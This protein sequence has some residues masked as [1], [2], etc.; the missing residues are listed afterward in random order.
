M[1][2][3]FWQLQ[4]WLNRTYVTWQMKIYNCYIFPMYENISE[5]EIPIL[6][7]EIY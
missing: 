2:F 5:T 4:G 1:S 7:I 3:L 6:Q